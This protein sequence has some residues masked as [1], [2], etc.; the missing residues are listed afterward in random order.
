MNQLKIIASDARGIARRCGWWVAARW[1]WCIAL[2]LPACL[3][4]RNLQPADIRMGNGPFLVDR[5]GAQAQLTGQ[6]VFSGIREIWVR[7]VYL[8]DNYLAI[9]KGALV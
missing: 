8:R 9:P 3:K 4:T 1:L 6:Q 7:D 2:T 5:D